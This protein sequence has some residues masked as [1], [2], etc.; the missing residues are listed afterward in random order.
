MF[1]FT[2]HKSALARHYAELAAHPGWIDHARLIV[3]ELKAQFPDF[4]GDLPELVREEIARRKDDRSPAVPA[5]RTDAEPS[6]GCALGS[7]VKSEGE[8]QK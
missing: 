2:A 4:Y 5:E 6:E 1:D 3:K 8:I 7:A